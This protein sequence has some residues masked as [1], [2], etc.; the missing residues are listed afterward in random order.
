MTR[1]ITAASGDTIEIDQQA[2][3]EATVHVVDALSI[4]AIN[5]ALAARRPLLV[6]GEPG[7]GKSQLAR[8]AAQLLRRAFV[9]FTVDHRSEPHDLMWQLDAVARLAEAQILGSIHGLSEETL[10]KKIALANF[11]APGPLWWAMNWQSAAS[12]AKVTDTG[13]PFCPEGWSPEDGVV[14]LI[15]EIDKADAA[16]PNGLLEC[17]G[18][19]AFRCPSGVHVALNHGTPPL[20]VVTTNEE[21]ALP[22]AFIRRCMVR[23]LALPTEKTELIRFLVERGRAHIPEAD[24]DNGVLNEAASLL[25]A[26]REAAQDRDLGPPGCAEYLDLLYAL[27]ELKQDQQA[28]PGEMLGRLKTF[29]YQKHPPEHR[30]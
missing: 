15:D 22:D 20:V 23:Q 8:V 24:L 7:T 11:I 28:D 30:R 12:Q 29:A 14:V 3:L 10:M 17:L 13:M 2:G 21:R 16:V 26:D 4:D 27:R 19:R 9:P 5:A 1:Y 25:V 6:R 18:N